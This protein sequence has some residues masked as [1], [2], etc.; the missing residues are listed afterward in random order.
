MSEHPV[1]MTRAKDGA[2]ALVESWE[3]KLWEGYGFQMAAP[4]VDVVDPTPEQAV[5][6]KRNRK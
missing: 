2:K 4:D 1:Q 5:P 6:A 3:V